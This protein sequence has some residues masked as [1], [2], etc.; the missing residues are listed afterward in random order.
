MMTREFGAWGRSGGRAGRPGRERVPR[1]FPPMPLFF[2]FMLLLHLSFAGGLNAQQ[3]LKGPFLRAALD[4]DSARIGSRVVLTL[5]YRLPPQAGFPDVP[6][7]GG[8]EE[9]AEVDR[10]LGPRSIRITLLVDRLHSWKTGPLSLS[11]MDSEGELRMLKA[12]PVSLTVQSNLGEKPEKAELR[13]IKDIIPT[14]S[15]LKKFLAWAAALSGLVLAVLA[16]LWWR[17]RR[18]IRDISAFAAD[19]PHIR[20]LREMEELDALRLFEEGNVKEYYFRFSG[21]V[22]TYIESLRGFPAAEYTTEEISLRM[23]R[24]EDR[25]LIPILQKADM[26]KFADHL[27]TRAGKE[28]AMETVLSY[29]KETGPRDTVAVGEDLSG[30]ARHA[31]RDT[32]EAPL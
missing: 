2:S 6:H 14:H 18:R 15:P 17:R 28:A 11:Y 29:I 7:I 27:P 9:L 23:D 24:E 25:R 22:R 8:L 26:V 5:E 3:S 20:A 16:L 12:N 19:P 30:T 13:P 21:I 32:G 31:G 1:P 10:E 4:R